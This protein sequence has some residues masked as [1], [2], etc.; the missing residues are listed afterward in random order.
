MKPQYLVS[1]FAK[2]DHIHLAVDLLTPDTTTTYWGNAELYH[3]Y[4]ILLH[5]GRAGWQS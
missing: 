4:A 1:G 5:G 2:S 3:S